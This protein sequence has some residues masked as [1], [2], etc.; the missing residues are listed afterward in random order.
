VIH[1]FDLAAAAGLL[2]LCSATGQVA[3]AVPLAVA[4]A[5]VGLQSLPSYP[6]NPIADH[7]LVVRSSSSSSSPSCFSSLVKKAEVLLFACAAHAGNSVMSVAR[8]QTML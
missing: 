1:S 8:Q 6:T 2:L 3:V 7:S 5:V 4:M